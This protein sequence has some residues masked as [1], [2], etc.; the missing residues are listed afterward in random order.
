MTYKFGEKVKANAKRNFER[1]QGS[2]PWLNNELRFNHPF[3]LNQ[4]L[5]DKLDIILEL[6]CISKRKENYL[7]LEIL[8]ANLLR[9][10]AIR[11]VMV[12]MNV[13]YWRKTR[14]TRA[15]ESTTKLIYKLDDHG[16]IMLKKGYRIDGESRRVD[17]P[18]YCRHLLTSTRS[19]FKLIGAELPQ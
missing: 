8:I 18:R 10:R 5:Q 2:G 7:N 13:N 14:Y 17:F 9:K 4:N 6:C 15:G 12:S 1:V 16:Y 11:H 19:P 3:R